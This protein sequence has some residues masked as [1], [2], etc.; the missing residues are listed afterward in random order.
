M[1]TKKTTTKKTELAT[2]TDAPL[3]IPDWMQTEEIVGVEQV[4]EHMTTPRLAIVQAMSEEDRKEA[5]GEGGVAIMPDG[6]KVADKGE[7]F[8]AIPLVFWP[9]WEVWSDINDTTAPMIEDSTQDPNSD[10]ARRARTKEAREEMYGDGFK[11]RYVES[12]NFIMRID[13]GPAAGELATLSFTVGEHYTGSKLCG[14]LKRRPCSI[15]ANRISFTTAL[16][17][18]NNRSWYGFDFNNPEVDPVVQDKE[19]Y[20]KLAAMHADLSRLV[21]SAKIMV[22]R[23]DNVESVETTTVETDSIPI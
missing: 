1:T 6:V 18:R 13:S 15:F 9:S 22:N 10:I 19:Q 4:G 14:M 17:K 11:R 8:V 23:E 3:V 12:L 16:R 7:E 2:T 20:D 5:F 21:D